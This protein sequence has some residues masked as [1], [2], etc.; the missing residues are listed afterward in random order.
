MFKKIKLHAKEIHLSLGF[1]SVV[2]TR[3]TNAKETLALIS[4][5]FNG[6]LS[7]KFMTILAQ[8]GLILKREF[9]RKSLI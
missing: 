9:Y 3:K 8:S 5:R 4:F 6:R 2:N 7:G 1:F